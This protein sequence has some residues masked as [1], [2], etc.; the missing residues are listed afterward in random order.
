VNDGNES[1]GIESVE[2]SPN[3]QTTEI[4]ENG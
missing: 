4:T 1:H 2:L 3:K